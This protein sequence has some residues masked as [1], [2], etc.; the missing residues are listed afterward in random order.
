MPTDSISY[1]ENLVDFFWGKLSFRIAFML[2]VKCS[3]FFRKSL[4]HKDHPRHGLWQK[5]NQVT[6]QRYIIVSGIIDWIN[7]VR[8]KENV[9]FNRTKYRNSVSYPDIFLSVI[10]LGLLMNE[11]FYR[12]VIE[13]DRVWSFKFSEEALQRCSW[14]RVLR[15]Y[16]TNLQENTHTEVWFQQTCFGIIIIIIALFIL[17]KNNVFKMYK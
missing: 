9:S 8:I 14:E 17:G 16:A 10:L 6:I 11:I 13:N 12:R 7:L 3:S 5:R 4:D 15:K 2:W 1:I